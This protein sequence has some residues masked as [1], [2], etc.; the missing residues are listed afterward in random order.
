MSYKFLKAMKL[1]VTQEAINSCYDLLGLDSFEAVRIQ[2][3]NERSF[4]KSLLLSLSGKH[5]TIFI[6]F[7]ITHGDCYMLIS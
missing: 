6:I 3:R 5:D 1:L 7:S 2:N 4:V